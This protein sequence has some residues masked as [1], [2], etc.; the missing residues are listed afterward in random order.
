MRSFML[1]ALCI[2]HILASPI[3]DAPLSGYERARR[4][5]AVSAG[6][7]LARGIDEVKI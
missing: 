3:N 7:V 5:P 4:F 1:L 6:S 2:S